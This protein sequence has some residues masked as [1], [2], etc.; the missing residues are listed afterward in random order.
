M[1]HFRLQRGAVVDIRTPRGEDLLQIGAPQ[2]AADLGREAGIGEDVWNCAPIALFGVR[3]YTTAFA[4]AEAFGG[5]I[6]RR[7][8]YATARLESP[9]CSSTPREIWRRSLWL[10]APLGDFGSS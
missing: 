9:W 3:I 1:P 5:I 10:R 8:P 6:E 7:W 4:L 2:L